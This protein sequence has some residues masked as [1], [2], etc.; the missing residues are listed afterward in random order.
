VPRLSPLGFPYVRWIAYLLILL[1]YLAA[2]V[3]DVQEIDATQY[4]VMSRELPS[5]G[6]GVSLIWT[7]RR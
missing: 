3:I 1:A 7:S 6:T 5:F 2:L 4:A